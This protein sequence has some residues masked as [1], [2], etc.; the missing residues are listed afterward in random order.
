MSVWLGATCKWQSCCCSTAPI[1]S[2]KTPG[3]VLLTVAHSVCI[4]HWQISRRRSCL[5]GRLIFNQGSVSCRGLTSVDIAINK[6]YVSMV[7][8]LELRSFFTGTLQLKVDSPLQTA[9]L[10][11]VGVMC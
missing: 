3:A 8:C 5:G 6:G 4:M 7:R 9:W 1:H 2:L 11:A 10:I